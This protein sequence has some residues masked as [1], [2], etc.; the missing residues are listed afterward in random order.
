[1]EKSLK[2][3]KEDQTELKSKKEKLDEDNNLLNENVR[4]SKEEI[5]SLKK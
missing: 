4:L 2:V 3:A 5:T 1:M